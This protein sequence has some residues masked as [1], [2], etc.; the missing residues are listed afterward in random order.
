MRFYVTFS[1]ISSSS[2]DDDNGGDGGGVGVT[3]EQKFFFWFVL[4]YIVKQTENC[5]ISFHAEYV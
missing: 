3:I 4:N 2:D 5:N 1:I